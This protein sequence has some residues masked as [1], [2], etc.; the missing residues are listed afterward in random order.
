MIA[1][2]KETAQDLIARAKRTL[3]NRQGDTGASDCV[4]ELL[5]TSYPEADPGEVCH[6][7]IV[8]SVSAEFEKIKRGAAADEDKW[9]KVGQL[10]LFDSQEF[11]V[12]QF[13]L[14]KSIQE[15]DEFMT[16]KAK[17][18][19][20]AAEALAEAWRK[21]DS[22]AQKI[23]TWASNLHGLRESVEAH[24]MNPRE[25]SIEQAI[26]EAKKIQPGYSADIGPK[27]GGTLRSLRP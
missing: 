2:I 7:V 1:T 15:A 18:E 9:V 24:G 11:F 20:E 26:A 27:A 12:P 22:K 10:S 14:P 3:I 4:D 23:A 8:N 13:L 17:A 19:T 21:Q 6:Q 25:T 16:A 5:A